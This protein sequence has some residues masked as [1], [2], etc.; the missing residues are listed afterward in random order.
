MRMANAL[1]SSG[2]IELNDT[3][4]LGVAD[5]RKSQL[6][7]CT[8]AWKLTDSGGLPLTSSLGFILAD[9]ADPSSAL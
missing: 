7:R 5:H 4:Q 3:E 6:M 2:L 9:N 8:F 1:Q